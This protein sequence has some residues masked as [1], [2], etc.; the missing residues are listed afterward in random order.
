MSNH[1][2]SSSVPLFRSL[3]NGTVEQT[4]HQRNSSWNTNGTWSLKALAR[5]VLERNKQWNNPGTE[6]SKSVPFLPQCSTAGGTKEIAAARTDKTDRFETEP[7][8]S[9]LSVP[10]Q[11]YFTD[12][13]LPPLT[14][15][16]IVES[17]EERLAIAEYDGYQTPS[18]SQRIAYLDA[19]MAVLATLPQEISLEGDLG[20]NW[21]DYKI[22]AARQ[23]LTRQGLEEPQ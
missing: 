16:D 15:E 12:S 4:P 21:L 2:L 11:R 5:K 1:P 22:S 7:N 18:Q 6:A 9:V 23:W 17:F 3:E 8:M 13:T 14:R 19:F 20:R 10:S